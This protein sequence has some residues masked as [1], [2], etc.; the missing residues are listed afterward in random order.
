VNAALFAELLSRVEGDALESN[1]P[2]PVERGLMKARRTTGAAGFVVHPR[3][4]GDPRDPGE[5]GAL[6]GD[7]SSAS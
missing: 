5:F 3:S 4:P 6:N 7:R 1:I 2:Q